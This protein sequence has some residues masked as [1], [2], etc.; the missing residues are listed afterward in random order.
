MKSSA[1]NLLTLR[2]ASALRP[3]LVQ[4]PRA[5]RLSFYNNGSRS[6]LNNTLTPLQTLTASNILPYHASDLYALTADISSYS[7]FVPYCTSS[8]VISQSAPDSTHQKRWPRVAD[9][10][11]G[12]ESFNEVF[13]SR[14]YCQPNQILEAVAGEAVSSIPR[15]HLPHYY[16]EGGSSETESQSGSEDATRKIFSSLLTRWTFKEFPFKSPP[17]DGKRIHDAGHQED[18]GPRTE[19]NLVIEVRFASAVYAALSQAAAPKVAGMMIG[20][21]EKRAR[22]VLGSGHAEGREGIERAGKGGQSAL[23]GVTE[24]RG[25]KQTP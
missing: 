22:E 7:S 18:S 15:G 2:A 10:R 19:V 12:W 20:A 1:S 13:R 11:V 8:T 23:E 5:T 14:V 6:F 21:F 4:S 9:L 24:G 16:E 25:L 3:Q 17:T